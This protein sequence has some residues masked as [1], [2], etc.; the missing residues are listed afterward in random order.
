MSEKIV[1]NYGKFLPRWEVAVNTR[2]L[3]WMFMLLGLAVMLLGKGGAAQAEDLQLEYDCNNI[4]TIPLE[5]CEALLAIYHA[6][7]GDD[8]TFSTHWGSEDDPS[9]WHGVTISEGQVTRLN[10]PDNNLTGS[11]PVQ[12]GNLRHLTEFNLRENRLSGSLPVEI[13]N[14]TTLTSLDLSF[15]QFSGGLPAGLFNLTALEYLYLDNNQ[16]AGFVLAGIGNL[17]QLKVLWL[18]NNRL[19]GFPPA[20]ITNLSNLLDPGQVD[21]GDLDGLNLDGN[22][23]CIPDGFPHAGNAVHQFLHQKDPNFD[24]AQ[25]DCQP[26]FEIFLPLIKR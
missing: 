20:A 9:L 8:W 24:G 5:E 15:N 18:H 22:N 3:F 26:V 25:N 12:V 4:Q 17:N 10:L 16:F 14:L 21:P 7:G 19:I 13:G 1:Y 2:P 11:L 6:T 23:F